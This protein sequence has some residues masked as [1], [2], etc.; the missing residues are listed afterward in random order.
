MTTAHAPDGT[1]GP[2]RAIVTECA[3]AVL[4]GGATHAIFSNRWMAGGTN[5]ARTMRDGT[6]ALGVSPDRVIIPDNPEDPKVRS[7]FRE[8]E[9]ALGVCRA[10][11]WKSVIVVANHIHMRRVLA[12]WRVVLARSDYQVTLYWKSVGWNS[13]G[14]G[15]S[16]QSRLNHPLI[17]LAY[18][19]F[20]ACP[21]SII[22]GWWKFGK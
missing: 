15:I 22:F 11:G 10:N 20:V 18:E 17:F 6:I 7:T 16:S 13:Y 8:A 9:F 3:Q 1:L 21:A 12:A 19:L 2:V 5:L 14:K 4:G